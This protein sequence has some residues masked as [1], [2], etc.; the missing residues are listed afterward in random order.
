M[1]QVVF[2]RLMQ[3][4]FGH[5]VGELN[6]GTMQLSLQPLPRSHTTQFLPLCLWSPR[7]YYFS[8][9][10][11]DECQRVSKLLCGPFKRILGFL[12]AFHLTQTHGIPTDFHSQIL[13]ES[14]LPALVFWVWEPS[15]G[16]GPFTL[17]GKSP[18]QKYSSQF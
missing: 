9:G 17:K 16:L 2:T 15:I 4:R 5:V 18:Y 1:R 6:I 7:S 13:W 12:A 14:L 11:Q 8:T 3:I 10:A